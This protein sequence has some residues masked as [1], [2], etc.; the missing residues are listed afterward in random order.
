MIRRREVT[1]REVVEAHLGR[2]EAV[3]GAVNAIVRRLDEQALTAA[4]AADAALAEG[5]V[6]GPLHGVPCTVKE[7]IDVAGTPTTQGI[8]L[9][10]EAMATVDGPAVERLRAAGAIPIG[11]TNLPDLAMR[12]HTDS[13]LH[14]LTLNPRDPKLTAGGSSGGEAVALATGM[15]PLGLGTDLGGSVRNP[16]HCCGIA[17]LKPT[18]GVVA[19]AS[20]LPPQDFGIAVQLM[21]VEGVMARR[22]T[23]LKTALSVVAGAHPRD[24]KS[25]PVT[26]PDS[27]DRSLRIASCADPPGGDTHPDVVAGIRGAAETLA[28]AGHEVVE[29]VPESYSRAIELWGLVLVP[30]LAGLAELLRSVIGADG[31]AFLE[32]TQAAVGEV[33]TAEWSAALTERHAVA[34]AWEQFFSDYDVLLTPTWAAP[35]FP[36]GADIIDLD[37]TRSTL[38]TVR[39][40]LPANLLG[41]PAA[42]APAAVVNGLPVGAQFTSRRFGERT[43]LAAAQALEDTVGILTPIDPKGAT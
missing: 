8:P 13:S 18:T 43:T 40:T 21:G 19:A 4:D 1:S 9:M 20:Q 32:L 37:H 41:L 29:A 15:S 14:G 27:P 33:S 28:A 10:A 39:P 35:P 22:V 34:R 11:R 7:S 36:H 2:I 38:A 30:D 12:M 26:L 25:L 17:S 6:V 3:N 5:N 24:P 16:A 23:D 42:V 31:Y